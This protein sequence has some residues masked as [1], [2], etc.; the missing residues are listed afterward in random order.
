MGLDGQSAIAEG[1]RCLT[2]D[3]R[4][5]IKPAILPPERWFVLA[6]ENILGIPEE[7][8]VYVLFNEEKE[9]YQITGTE[10]LKDSLFQELQAK[11][12]KRG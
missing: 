4:F 8:G 6:E 2:C 1:R 9:T 10:N 11:C 5:R 3:L 12:N 7:E